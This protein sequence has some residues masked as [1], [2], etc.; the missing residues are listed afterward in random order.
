MPTAGAFPEALVAGLHVETDVPFADPLP[1][2]AGECAVPLDILAPEDGDAMPTIVLL[3]GGPGAFH[4]R[5][6]LEALATELAR[7]DAVVFLATYRSDATGNST[8]TSRTDVRCAI[9]FARSRTGE[10]GGDPDRL[11][12]VGHSFGSNLALGTAA[13]VDAAAP[14][15]LADAP[16][17]PDGAVG[18]SGFL[19]AVDDPVD[20]DLPFLLMSGSDDP[21]AE[22]GEASAEELRLAGF[23]AE[24][25]ELEGIDHF[26]IVDPE[27][28]PEVVDRILE[29]SETA[30]D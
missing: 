22:M 14:G 29:L 8:D 16:G 23:E 9:Q 20:A 21:A 4:E 30:G 19:F 27:V 5:R 26:E 6:Y 13:N 24:Y 10:L 15:C 7:R 25:V 3:P 18:L 1:C 12:L 2:G 11:T 17:V 28:T